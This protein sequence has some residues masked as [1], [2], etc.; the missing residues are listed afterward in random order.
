[1]LESLRTLA[2]IPDVLRGIVHISELDIMIR[3]QS[4]IKIP[5]ELQQSAITLDYTDDLIEYA[6]EPEMRLIL[7][8]YARNHASMTLLF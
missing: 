3:R 2:A 5:K 6:R 7:K 4:D 8:Q 1:M